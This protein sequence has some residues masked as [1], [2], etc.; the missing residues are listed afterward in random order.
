VTKEVARAVLLQE[1]RLA[2][3]EGEEVAAVQKLWRV[4]QAKVAVAAVQKL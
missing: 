2:K 3:V 4:R 1:R